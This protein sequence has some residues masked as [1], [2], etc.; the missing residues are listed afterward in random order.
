V[1]DLECGH[2]QH[3]RHS[4]PWVNRPW[5]ARPEGRNGMI[6]AAL[7][8]KRCDEEIEGAKRMSGRA[9]DGA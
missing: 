4:P 6:G 3:V 9:P 5:V 7:N 1:A 8:C 2:A